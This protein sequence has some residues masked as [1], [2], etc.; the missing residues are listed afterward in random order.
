MLSRIDGLAFQCFLSKEM[1][2]SSALFSDEENGPRGDLT[3][4]TVDGDLEAAQERKLHH[5]LKTARAKA[6]DRLLEFGTGWGALA[7][8]AAKHYGC[9]VDTLTLSVEQKALA[10][11]RIAAEGLS[12]KI[13]VHLMD[14][15]DLPKHFTGQFDVFVSIEMIEH[16][17]SKH[18]ER[19]FKIVDWVLKKD[20]GRAVVTSSTFPE[21]RYS[22]YQEEDFIR[23][24][25]WP[26]SSIPSATALIT[27]AATAS[28]SNLVLDGVEN[29]G[30]HYARTLREWG[31]RLEANL[32]QWK[33][34]ILA[35]QPALRNALEFEAFI[36]K[37][38]YMFVYAGA[39]FEKGYL[40]CH[41][42]SWRRENLV[43][44]GYE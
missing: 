39:G 40:T 20:T 9:Q 15:R 36:R 44:I 8:T 28:G 33:D 22:K 24:Y 34:A 6:G 11:E 18:Y 14:Y 5:V 43:P 13:T 41:M 30:A 37:W 35:D 38:R 16:V 19:Y 32:P 4:G 7:I 12:D 31:R 25:M 29:H 23:R 26:N 27:A 10:E 42:I 17:G 3:H 1:Q 21:A 2:Y